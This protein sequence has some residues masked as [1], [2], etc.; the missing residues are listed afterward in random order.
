LELLFQGRAWAPIVASD[1]ASGGR[2]AL[3]GSAG[4]GFRTGPYFSFGVE[5]SAVRASSRGGRRNT[6][7][8]LAALGRVYLLEEGV[9]DPYLELA[10]GY[11]VTAR[12]SD[13]ADAI[14]HGPSAR[15]G[16]GVDVVVLS[17]LRFGL[18]LAYREAVGWAETNCAFE[19]EPRAHGGILAGVAVTF[20]LGEPL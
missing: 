14:D 20:P 9:L 17:P 18:L 16:G 15:A 7:L 10:L 2:A 1:E 12:A 4:A 5:G 13:G 19:C 3:G 11:A 8:E 6:T